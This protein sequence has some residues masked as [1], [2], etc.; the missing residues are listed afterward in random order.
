MKT[1]Y[2]LTFIVCF[3]IWSCDDQLEILPRNIIT[4]DQVFSNESAI[5]AYMASLY[6]AL[7]VE[8]FNFSANNGFNSWSSG[9]TPAHASGE[10]LSCEPRGDVGDGTWWNWW[11]GNNNQNDA[12][13]T[14]RNVNSFI[15]NVPAANLTEEKKKLYLGEAMFIRAYDYFALVKRYGGV[16]L[17]R[18]VQTFTGSNLDEMQVPRN[19]EKEVY[20]FIAAQL[21]SAALLLPASN[22]RGRANKNVALALKSRAMLYAGCEAK[23]GSVQLNGL[24]GIPA[25]EADGY[26]QQSFDA[27]EAVIESNA[28]SLYNVKADKSENFS[29]LF[30][31][32]TANPEVM[33][34]KDY[35]F[36]EMVHSFDMWNLPYGV[37]GAWGYSSRT[38]PTLELVEMFEYKDGSAGTLEITDALG[39]PVTYDNPA[40]LYKDKDPRL[41]GTVIMPFSVWRGTVID[42][43][44]GV[45]DDATTET[46]VATVY[47]RKTVTTG[48]YNKLYNTATHKIGDGGTQKIISTNGIGGGERSITG[49]YNRKYMN[50][51]MPPNQAIGWNSTQSW[52]D[53][54]YAE[55]LLNYAEAAIELDDD[56]NAKTAVNLIRDRAGIVPL[57]DAEVTRDRIRHERQAEL[58]LENHKYWDIRRWHVGDQLI[59]NTKLSGLYPY[60][61]LQADT[62]VFTKVPVG[63]ILTFWPKLYYEKI[64]PSEIQKNPKLVQNPLY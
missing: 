22:G 21:D 8:D 38:N 63:N 32:T 43:Q 60:Y 17:I 64:D 33:L 50:Y 14:I 13:A 37:R 29:D 10:V 39:D 47:G 36:P 1:R 12:Y 18:K 35:H 9:V 28:Y 27:A 19:T 46:N 2:I 31:N 52:I 4:N 48:D 56:A 5:T 6:T 7:P 16:P 24:V 55:V 51:N 20:D 34:V 44:A 41:L 61:D 53:M 45:I 54:R 59:V 42:V 57:N 3:L 40:D 25:S 62:Y 58:A 15:E 23:Y 30:I 11:M 26:F 49:F